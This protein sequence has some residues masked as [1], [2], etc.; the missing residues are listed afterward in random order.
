MRP[1]TMSDDLNSIKLKSDEK[2]N[3][4]IAKK[5]SVMSRDKLC[6][7][8]IGLTM[9]RKIIILCLIILQSLKITSAAFTTGNKLLIDNYNLKKKHFYT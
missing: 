8:F 5:L 1:W 7:P 3:N 6:K 9:I 4:I 2:F